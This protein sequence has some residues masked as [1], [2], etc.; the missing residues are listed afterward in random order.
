MAYCPFSMSREREKRSCS[1]LDCAWWSHKRGDC[2]VFRIADALDRLSG[3][4]HQKNEE[5]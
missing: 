2:V 3:A 5:S 4:G 1:G